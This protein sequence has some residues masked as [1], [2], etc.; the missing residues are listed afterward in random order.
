[1]KLSVLLTKGYRLLSLAAIVDVFE[2]ANRF[3]ESEGK[4]AFFD[5]HMVGKDKE[6]SLPDSFQ[7]YAYFEFS[8]PELQSDAMIIPAFANREM[9]KNI[10]NNLM[11]LPFLQ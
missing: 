2:T 9:E 4:A 7:E 10:S 6:S 5:L 8:D 11:F 1:M 3:L